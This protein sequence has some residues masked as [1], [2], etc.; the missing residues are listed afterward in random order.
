MHWLTQNYQWIFSGI[1]VL[2]LA[3]LF[4]RMRRSSR[5]GEGSLTAQG[6]KVSRS[7]VASGS[8]IVQN[9]TETTATHHHY[10]EAAAK[11]EVP[12]TEVEKPKPNIALSWFGV[13]EIEE[14]L[15]GGSFL[16]KDNGEFDAA[17]IQFSN[18]A[19][20]GTKVLGVAVKPTISYRR[21]SEEFL[22]VTGSWLD[23]GTGPLHFAVDDSH[24]LIIGIVT[25]DEFCVPEGREA[26]IRR[27]HFWYTQARRFKDLDT[28]SVVVRLTNEYTG[29]C[30]FEGGFDISFKPLKI[31]R[32]ISVGPRE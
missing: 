13:N 3:L 5:N 2:L 22:R 12:S 15:D 7:P 30:F 23:K 11:I 21:N 16:Q 19:I 9:I 24:K 8:G 14:T 20:L 28:F 1:G 29:Y 17:I 32:Q 25:G 6:A 4:E 10:A 18:D 27:R 31:S 26:T